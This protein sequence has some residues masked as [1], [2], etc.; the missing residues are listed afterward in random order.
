MPSPSMT[1]TPPPRCTGDCDNS[2]TVLINELVLMVNIALE[3]QPLSACP[4]ADVDF[5]GTTTVEEILI[6]VNYAQRGCPD[7]IVP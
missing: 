2:H 7:S 4:A 5:S 3:R 6:G 1:A